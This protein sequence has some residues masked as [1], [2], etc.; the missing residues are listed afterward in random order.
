MNRRHFLRGFSATA[1]GA[2]ALTLE[3]PFGF[4]LRFARAGTLP[5]RVLVVVF[6]RG[7]CDGLNT[8]V[9]FG[10]G[11][12]YGLR[13]T[14]GVPAPGP[15]PECALNLDGFFGLHPSL[16][17][18]LP[19][20]HQGE[21]AVLPAVQYPDAS[22][23]HFSGQRLIESGAPAQELQGWL[24][25][26]LQTQSVQVGFGALGVGS[27]PHALQG[28]KRVSVLGDDVSFRLAVP[29]AE[30][31]PLR[32]RLAAAYDPSLADS[33]AART[34][35]HEFGTRFLED[36]ALLNSIDLDAIPARADYPST[37]FGRGMRRLAQF[38]KL[39]RQ[40]P[41]FAIEAATINI[42]GWDTHSGQGG[43]EA[44]G[45][46]A[47]RLQDFGDSLAAFYADLGELRDDVL[48]LTQTEFGRT[49]EENGSFGTDHGHAAAWFL[50]GPRVNGGHHV[51][52]WPGLASHA[53]LQGRYLD[54]TVD[55]RDVYADVLENHLGVADASQVLPDQ[56]DGHVPTP[57][58]L[59]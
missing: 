8:V 58:G 39:G 7:G 6:Q 16:D 32:R 53:L 28:A 12:Y 20:W 55:Y 23:S 19:V 42:G 22:R 51:G 48:T 59:L 43:G 15:A 4:S 1:F 56:D 33:R 3:H 54:H 25:A 47:R 34:L 46:Q 13:P 10:D 37:G 27:L 35:L 44:S 21:L 5:G 26:Y 11:D 2:T 40:Q 57:I 38:L 50:L 9:P 36:I 45:R 31:A 52:T 14:I 49:A 29:A 17:G 30:D 18:L 24:N 41:A